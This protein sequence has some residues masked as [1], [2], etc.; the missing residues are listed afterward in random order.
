MEA[1]VKAT[2]STL[3]PS[4]LTEKFLVK[5]KRGAGFQ[6]LKIATAASLDFA[7]GTGASVSVVH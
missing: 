1:M 7:T 2:S 5:K 6:L 3:S 4:V